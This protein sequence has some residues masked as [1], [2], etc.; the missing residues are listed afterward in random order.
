MKKLFLITLLA[1]ILAPNLS[2]ASPFTYD[3]NFPNKNVPSVTYATVTGKVDE[4]DNSIFHFKVDLAS[5]AST[6]LNGGSDFGLTNFFFNTNLDLTNAIIKNWDPVEWT[7]A[8]PAGYVGNSGWGQFDVKLSDSDGV[9]HLYF[10][11]DFT[12]EVTVTEANFNL[13]SDLPADNGQGHFAVRIAGFD[14]TDP[15]DCDTNYSAIFVRDNAQD[16]S[17][18]S[19]PDASIMFLL[20][21]GLVGLGLFGRRKLFKK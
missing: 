20:G 3:L 2:S 8:S 1:G 10:D 4:I 13:L 12:S 18:E 5:D 15:N 19:V 14:Y 21:P 11:I 9:H 16:Q 7:I 17:G 6:T